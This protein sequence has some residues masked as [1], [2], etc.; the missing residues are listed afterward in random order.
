[1]PDVFSYTQQLPIKHVRLVLGNQCVDFL[2]SLV[3]VEIAALHGQSLKESANKSQKNLQLVESDKVDGLAIR[4]QSTK[5]VL[6]AYL[7]VV[8]QGTE[9][10]FVML[11]K[12]L[13]LV[14]SPQLVAFFKRIGYAGQKYEYLHLVG[15]REQI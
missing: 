2:G 6:L 13:Y 5:S 12:L 15:F 10:D 3:V 11:R 14:E 9:D 4:L 1:M 8:I 7:G